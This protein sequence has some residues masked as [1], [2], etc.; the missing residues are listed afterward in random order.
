MRSVFSMPSPANCVRCHVFSCETVC[1]VH[2]IIPRSLPFAVKSIPLKSWKPHP[3]FQEIRFVFGPDAGGRDEHRLSLQRSV[4]SCALGERRASWNC[5]GAV[6][7]EHADPSLRGGRLLPGLRP[8]AGRPAVCLQ[9]ATCPSRP[10]EAHEPPPPCFRGHGVMLL[11]LLGQGG[12][13]TL[14]GN[15]VGTMAR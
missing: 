12:A 7:A 15:Q 10:H 9:G 1:L 3:R 13:K 2:I 11:W 5:R 8:R 6:T 14:H 4:L